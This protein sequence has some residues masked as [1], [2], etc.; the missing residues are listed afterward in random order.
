MTEVFKSAKS[1]YLRLFLNDGFIIFSLYSFVFLYYGISDF[2]NSTVI[3]ICSYILYFGAILKIFQLRYYI[4]KITY[5][6]LGV[7]INYYYFFR[8]E[9]IFIRWDSFATVNKVF[10]YTLTE[11]IYKVVFYK[12]GKKAIIQNGKFGLESTD[13]TSAKVLEVESLLNKIKNEILNK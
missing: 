8:H 6:D 7:S 3:Q 1:A 2:S 12:S 4:D 11:K 13:W 9:N 5:D 10:Q